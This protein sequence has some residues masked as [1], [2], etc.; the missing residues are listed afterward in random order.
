MKSYKLLTALLLLIAI[1]S[2][3][4]SHLI[5]QEK[6]INFGLYGG[7]N[8]NMHS[9]S[10]KPG[11]ILLNNNTKSSLS[12][13]FS[14]NSTGI[15]TYIGALANFPINNTFSISAR[16][17]YNG[18]RGLITQDSLIP[19]TNQVVEKR[20]ETS[21]D[22]FEIFPALRIHNLLGNNP[23]YL[24]A[25]L[26][27]GIPVSAQY[28]FG[29][30]KTSDEYNDIPD[31]N[32]RMAL[33]LGA[34]YE[35]SIDKRF[36][37]TPEASF[38]IPF[39]KVS[40]ANDWSPW[41]ASQ[42]RLGVSVTYS[43]TD[44]NSNQVPQTEEN[45]LKVGFSEVK[46]Y[47]KQFKSYPLKKVTV[48]ETQYAELFPL[49]P[50]V[51]F[52]QKSTDMNEN[53]NLSGKRQAGSFTMAEL[54][55]DAVLINNQTLDII[56]YR[57]N[58]NKNAKITLT[59]T[60]DS[61]DEID[62]KLAENRA[63][64]TKKYLVDNYDIESNRIETASTKLPSKPSTLKD[65]DGI[66]ENRRVEITST[67]QDILAPILIEKD[68]QRIADPD[69][70]EFVPNISTSHPIKS[71]DLDIKQSGKTIRRF[72]GKG[73]IKPIKWAIIPNELTASQIPLDYTLT[74]E[75]ESG[76][77]E[78]SVGSVPVE[79]FSFTRKKTEDKADKSVSKYS[80][81]VFD[82]D[83]PEISEQDRSIIDKHVIPAIKQ[84][85]TVQIYGYTDR[86]GDASYN[87]KLA[88]QRAENVKKYIESKS[89]SSKFET[90]GIGENELVYD[91]EYPS[92]RFL[93]RTVQIIVITPKN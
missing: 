55:P 67:N 14:E 77:V 15:F 37:V 56:G 61:K 2:T 62:A 92:G 42:L 9:P 75:T 50:Y 45:Y 52:N 49:L 27:F 1:I 18:I 32:L 12:T 26:D 87:K 85:S 22:Y 58:E 54:A 19:S 17:G 51:F 24:L 78:S 38:H 13:E 28:S 6:P 23:A 59:G 73:E 65:P 34:G 72:N 11:L 20:L 81:V 7:I 89:K 40:S 79:F 80:L 82:F 83:S 91:N 21:L 74:V 64:L 31:K 48:E 44:D 53:T 8:I 35:F 88:L 76:L 71:W 4:P 10:M 63:Q 86:I 30:D 3:S 36:K 57:M 16:I 69:L 90:Y 43:L 84:N 60:I 46:Y 47:D 70:V 41:S 25:G 5:S 66:A 33:A 29:I 39:T 93:S 68:R